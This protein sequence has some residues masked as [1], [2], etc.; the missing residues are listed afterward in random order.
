M[1]TSCLSN[2]YFSRSSTVPFVS[3]FVNLSAAFSEA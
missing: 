3:I 1:S 2:S